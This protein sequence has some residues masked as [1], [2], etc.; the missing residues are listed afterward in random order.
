MLHLL[1]L[2][3]NSGIFQATYVVRRVVFT[4]FFLYFHFFSWV[5]LHKKKLIYLSQQ[6][7]FSDH[8]SLSTCLLL[9]R[10]FLEPQQHSVGRQGTCTMGWVDQ[11]T[12][13]FTQNQETLKT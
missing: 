8:M 9:T 7:L 5:N 3:H 10:V 13:Y 2:K 12:H 4:T 11:Y 1:H 6:S